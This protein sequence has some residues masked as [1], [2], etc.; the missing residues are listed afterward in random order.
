MLGLGGLLGLGRWPGTGR[1]LGVG[2]LGVIHR[3]RDP[4]HSTV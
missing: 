1:H 4:F 3:L 2:G